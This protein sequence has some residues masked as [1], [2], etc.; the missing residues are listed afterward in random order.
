[1][2]DKN[3]SDLVSENPQYGKIICR[4]ERITE[5]EVV[6]SINRKCGARSIVGV[7]NRVRAGAGRCQGGFCQTEILRIL[8][9]ELK[10]D[11]MKVNYQREGSY[12]LKGRTKGE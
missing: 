4:C 9:R 10:I 2:T 8:S 3:I 11:K 12:I 5:G 7:K 1:M 6:D